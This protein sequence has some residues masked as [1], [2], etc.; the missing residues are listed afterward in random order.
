VKEKPKDE[1]KLP[2]KKEG[3]KKWSISQLRDGKCWR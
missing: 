3:E 1:Q 2:E